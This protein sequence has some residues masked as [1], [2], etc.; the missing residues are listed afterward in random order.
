MSVLVQVFNRHKRIENGIVVS[1]DT[2]PRRV[3]L[4]FDNTYRRLKVSIIPT[5]SIKYATFDKE[6]GDVACYLGD[7]HDFRFEL[8]L[9]PNGNAIKR[10]SVFRD[11]K[12][13]EI[14]YIGDPHDEMHAMY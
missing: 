4:G 9:F 14:Q 7:D 8:E 13:L 2:V 6:D 1:D 11:D 12:G 5:L 3:N 10:F